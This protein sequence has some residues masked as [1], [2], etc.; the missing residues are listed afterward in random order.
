MLVNKQS[1]LQRLNNATHSS[2]LNGLAAA[3]QRNSRVSSSAG[4]GV[5]DIDRLWADQHMYAPAS[6]AAA[7]ALASASDAAEAAALASPVPGQVA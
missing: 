3:G 5:G 4:R 7:E 2:D 1:G 6:L